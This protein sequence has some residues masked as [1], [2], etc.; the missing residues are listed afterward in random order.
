MKV[1]AARI[2]LFAPAPRGRVVEHQPER[3]LSLR[4]ST[5]FKDTRAALQAGDS[6]HSDERSST[7][8]REVKSNLC[9]ERGK[10][11]NIACRTGKRIV[12]AVLAE[13]FFSELALVWI[14]FSFLDFPINGSVIFEKAASIVGRDT[15]LG[16]ESRV[17]ELPPWRYGTWPS[18][19]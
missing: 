6:P 11:P 7:M 5:Y 4:F 1:L 3:S 15:A 16:P 14:S 2:N 13:K 10:S 17:T 9:E 8:R 19:S 12:S 18:Y